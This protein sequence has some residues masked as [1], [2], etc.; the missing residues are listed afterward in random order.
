M[1]TVK[2]MVSNLVGPRSTKLVVVLL[3][4]RKVSGFLLNM[5][6][7]LVKL[8]LTTEKVLKTFKR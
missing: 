2:H 5:D 4:S 1:M 3:T 8:L 7:G 6:D